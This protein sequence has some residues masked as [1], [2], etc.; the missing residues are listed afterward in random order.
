M[1]G[2]KL[3]EVAEDA[4][5]GNEMTNC[6]QNMDW[7]CEIFAHTRMDNSLLV[8]ATVNELMVPPVQVAI[9]DLEQEVA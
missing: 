9:V 5:A 1:V 7:D 6:T 8:Y 4:N 2:L 3:L